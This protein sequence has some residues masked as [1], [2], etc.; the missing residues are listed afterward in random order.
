MKFHADPSSAHSITAYGAGWI[1]VNRERFTSSV[2]ISAMGDRMA[3][4]CESYAEL[5]LLHFEQLAQMKPE[6]VVFG[7]G[8][9]LQLPRPEWQLALYSQGIGLETMDTH[10]ACRAYNFLVGEGRRVVAALL[11]HPCL[12]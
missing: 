6:L 5:Q 3:W 2:I 12:P 4:K 8:A 11:L 1:E 9:R 7:S 10:A